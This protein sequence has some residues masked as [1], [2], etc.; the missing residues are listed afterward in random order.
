MMP[1]A[2]ESTPSFAMLTTLTCHEQHCSWYSNEPG[3][4]GHQCSLFGHSLPNLRLMTTLAWLPGACQKTNCKGFPLFSCCDQ[5]RKVLGTWNF[6]KYNPSSIL[7][8]ASS[9]HKPCSSYN[10][11]QM[12]TSTSATSELTQQEDNSQLTQDMKVYNV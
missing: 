12:R 1:E 9:Q 11:Y 7:R 10:A 8:K 5:C 6:G 3:M 2:S 4:M